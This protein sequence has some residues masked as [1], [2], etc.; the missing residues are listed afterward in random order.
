[1]MWAFVPETQDIIEHS[2][3]QRGLFNYTF[4]VNN[5]KEID[6]IEYLISDNG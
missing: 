2:I 4:S 3:L 1:M 6:E 5:E